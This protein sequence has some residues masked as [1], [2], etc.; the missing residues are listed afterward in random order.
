VALF[1]FEG[2]DGRRPTEVAER[3]QITKQSVAELLRHLERC[4]YAKYKRDPSDNR[5]RLICLTQRGR[6]LEA[7]AHKH[8]I[9]AE[10]KLKRE[11]GRRR[12]RELCDTLLKMNKL[13]D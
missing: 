6:Q 5:A 10:R 9:V 11:L 4:G 3:M 12:F 13:A 1:C 7:A 2:L 8:A